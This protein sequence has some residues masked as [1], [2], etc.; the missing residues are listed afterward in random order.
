MKQLTR[1]FWI[2]LFVFGLVGQIAWTI[3]NMYLNVYIYKMFHASPADISLMVGASAAVATL[4]TWLMGAISDYFGKRKQ[5]ICIGYILWGISILGFR[6]I[7]TNY[8]LQNVTLGIQ[9]AILLDCLMTFF[10]S[11]AND[12]AFNAWLTD[13]GS[14]QNRGNIEG[15]NSI[16]P[17]LSMIVVFG[18]FMGFN[19]DEASSWQTIFTIIGCIILVIGLLGFVL[20]EEESVE[21]N[22]E[23]ILTILFYSLRKD[24]ILNNKMLYATLV[25]FMVFNISVQVF[26]P[27][28]ILY[29]EVGLQLTNYVLIF[30]PAVLIAALVTTK[31]SFIYDLQGLKLSSQISMGI[32]LLG[33]LILLLFT[34]TVMV[35]IGTLLLMIGYMNSLSVFSA[36]VRARMPENKSGQFQGIRMI[37]QVLIPGVVGPWI[38]SFLLRNADVITNSDGTTSFIPN[39]SIFVGALVVGVLVFVVLNQIFKMMRDSHYELLS[40]DAEEFIKSNEIPWTNHPRPQFK[41]DEFV[42]LNG[43]WKLEGEDILVP[44]APESFLSN[45]KGLIK[46]EMTYVKE[47]SKPE[48]NKDKVLLHF[49]AVDQICDV[50]LNNE[51]LGHHEGGYLPFSFDITNVLKE[52]NKLEVKVKDTLNIEYPYGKQTKN[53]GGMW[54]TPV[55]G[56]WQSVWLEN[57]CENYIEDLKITP[58]LKGA[59]IKLKGNISSF[60]VKVKTGEGRMRIYKFEGKEGYIDINHPILWTCENPYLYPIEISAGEDKVESYFALRTVRIKRVNGVNRVLL[61]NKPIFMHGLLDQ[62]YYCDGIYLPATELEYER[63]ILRMKELGFNLLRKHI[64]VEPE[65]YYYYCDKHGMLVMQDFVNNGQYDFIRDTVIPTYISKKKDDTK[66]PFDTKTHQIF[67][68]HSKQIVNHLY[69]HPSI[70]SYTIFNEGW[71]QFHSDAVYDMVKSWDKTRIYD[72]TSGWFSQKKNDFDSEHIYMKQIELKPQGRPY[73]VSECGGFTMRVKDHSYSMYNTYGYGVCEESEELTDKIIKMYKEMVLPG[74]SKGVC[75]CIYTQVSDVEDEINGLYT[76][77]RKV[78]KVLKKPLQEV[79]NEIKNIMSHL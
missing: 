77:D 3:E 31:L 22:K 16:L 75:G 51:Y 8:F 66:V 26:M 40:E 35:F 54:Y 76:Y 38:G 65:A 9:M 48:F 69:N 61:N 18:A 60:S 79:S 78:C 37:S 27:Y 21:R 12:A 23:S 63:D 7:S 67:I 43:I 24:V 34:N 52:N 29:F 17:I 55:S 19:L 20:I 71:G 13:K 62:G 44:F 30:A 15:Y 70:I 59:K 14:A 6:F 49:G 45:Y 41:R 50:Y 57:V 56:I 58:D 53:R 25:A 73:L 36:E 68:E 72:S 11:T 5:F 2:S 74:I 32:L 33:Y 46:D 64:K 47:F 1:K 10:G 39:R 42:S 28:L 4:T